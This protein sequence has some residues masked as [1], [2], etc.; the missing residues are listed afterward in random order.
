MRED[1]M[2]LDQNEVPAIPSFFARVGMV[3]FSPGDLFRALAKRPVWF[4]MA[5]FG[6]LVSG[7]AMLLI[8]AEAWTELFSGAA[9][10]DGQQVE[11]PAIVSQL[12][13]YLT[14]VLA[15]VGSILY[16]LVASLITY[17]VFV[18]IRR[19]KAKFSQH[20][21]VNSHVAIISAI[22]DWVMLWPRMQSLDPSR[23]ITVGTFFQFLPEGYLRSV[24]ENLDIF[25][26]WMAVVAGLGLSLLDSRRRWGPTAAILVGVTVGFALLMGL[27]R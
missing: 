19:D 22:A 5:A 1:Y 23:S 17:V 16:V 11:M 14:A 15:V 20:L 4:P 26:L 24:L 12:A 13:S 2:E 25:Q 27:F 18:F 21:A 3:F 7:A 6:G 9:G 10:P 8:P